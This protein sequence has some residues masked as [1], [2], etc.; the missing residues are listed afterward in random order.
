[1]FL[2]RFTEFVKST[3]YNNLGSQITDLMERD[4][5]SCYRYK[6]YF[7]SD[8][9]FFPELIRIY[10]IKIHIEFIFTF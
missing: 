9:K 8:K 5:I 6:N 4:K 10:K 2:D 1:M 7:M 3:K